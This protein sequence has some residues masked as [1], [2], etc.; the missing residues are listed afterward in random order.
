MAT[1]GIDILSQA[2]KRFGRSLT[3]EER[4]DYTARAPYLLATVCSEAKDLD[5]HYRAAHGIGK[6]PDFDEVEIDLESDFPLCDRFVGAASAYLAAMFII[7]D[8][9]TLSDKFFDVYCDNMAR[10]ATE[11]P[12]QI[13]IIAQK[14]L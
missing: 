13:E 11:I 4:E 3:D 12:T 2:L 9:V 8:N 6:A 7:D 5:E 10:I 14:Y 1:K